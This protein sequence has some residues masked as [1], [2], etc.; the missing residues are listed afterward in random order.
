MKEYHLNPPV[1]VSLILGKPLI[2]YL[3]MYERPMGYVLGQ[4]DNE[5]RC[6]EQGI[7]YLSK[8]FTKYE[9]GYFS[10]EKMCYALTWIAQ[11]LK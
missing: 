5:V 11:R 10:L 3:A 4:H 9:S 2:L 7:Y 1:L 6:K 8:K